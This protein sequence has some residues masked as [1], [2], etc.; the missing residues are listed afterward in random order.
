MKTQEKRKN[1]PPWK[2]K[3]LIMSYEII[4]LKTK[5]EMVSL[6]HSKCYALFKRI[7]SISFHENNP[8]QKMTIVKT[9]DFVVNRMS[10]YFTQ[11][12]KGATIVIIRFHFSL[13]IGIDLKIQNV[14]SIIRFSDLVNDNARIRKWL[15]FVIISNQ[16][17]L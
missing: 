10:W 4:L 12:K 2:W 9:M 1:G 3:F 16:N 14:F 11:R 7:E 8:I 5:N 13:K 17:W 6:N 15:G